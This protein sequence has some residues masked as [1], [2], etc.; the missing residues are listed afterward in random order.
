M[1]NYLS[2]GINH[3][4]G[5]EDFFFIEDIYTCSVFG[6]LKEQT[7]WK[8]LSNDEKRNSIIL[9]YPIVS[10]AIYFRLLS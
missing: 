2:R 5:Y 10:L 7:D 4:T 8:D 6:R 3:K 9:K 1:E